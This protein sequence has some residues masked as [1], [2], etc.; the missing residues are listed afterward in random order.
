M[1]F[2]GYFFFQNIYL[3]FLIF[4]EIFIFFL[5]ISVEFDKR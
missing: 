3:L 1:Y 2:E 5:I 4:F